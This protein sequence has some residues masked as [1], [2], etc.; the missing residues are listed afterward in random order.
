MSGE[1]TN[2]WRL[3]RRE[4]TSVG[5]V[6]Y[7]VFGEGPPVILVHGT[8]TRSYLWRGVAPTLAERS[9]VYVY[10][11]WAS[12]NPRGERARTCPSLP[13]PGCSRNW[14]GRGVWNGLRQWATT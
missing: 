10:D 9:R 8:P 7:E 13:R 3:G 1:Q 11:L 14:L 12:A 5:E 6:A 2:S 4:A